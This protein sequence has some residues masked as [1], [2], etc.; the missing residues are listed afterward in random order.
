M[1]D[2]TEEEQ[3]RVRIAM[4]VLRAQ[5]GG[6]KPMARALGISPRTAAN[7][8]CGDKAASVT[9][10]FRVAR[11]AGVGVDDVL[12]GKYPPV[13]VCPHCGQASQH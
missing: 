1:I 5:A 8:S 11:I 6:W 13:G 3:K 4:R 2:L 7:V 9:M 12:T 10:A